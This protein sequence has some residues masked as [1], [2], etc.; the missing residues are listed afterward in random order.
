MGD[1][2]PSSAAPREK[3][4]SLPRRRRYATV[5]VFTDGMFSGNPL[6]VVLEAEG[7]SAEQ[8]QTIA[9][10]FNYVET[11]FVFPPRDG[12]HT[13]HVRIF[14]P[15]REV[16]FAGHPNIGTAFILARRATDRGDPPLKNL[17]FEEAA[18]LVQIELIWENDSV[19][20]AE[21]LSPEPLARRS[22]VSPALAAACLGLTADDVSTE[23]NLPQVVSAG[24][25]SLVFEVKSRAALRRVLPDR[26]SFEKVFPLDG[27]QAIYVYTHDVGADTGCDV[28][29]RMFTR[30]MVEDPATGSAAAALTALLTEISGD[31]ETHLRIRQ[32]EDMGRPSLLLTRA[33]S[34]L[35]VTR[36]RVGGRC[37]AVFEGSFTL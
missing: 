31:S 5:D 2:S 18:G 14:T 29:A 25:P 1:P 7:L 27:A 9:R 22:E 3:N 24:L 33:Q 17:V 35:G 23:R 8:M 19:V 16:P 11:T 36:T 32:G 26:Q 10:E 13:A 34:H 28:H 15:D 20:G 37:V 21:L 12:S 6:A 4:Q 30:R